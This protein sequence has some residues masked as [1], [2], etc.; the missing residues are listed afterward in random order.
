M[1]H[2]F[3]SPE[4]VTEMAESPGT[5]ASRAYDVVLVSILALA[6]HAPEGPVTAVA[7]AVDAHYERA[8]S[9]AVYAYYLR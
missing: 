7:R 2:P 5:A 9:D 4:D 1:H 3:T 6:P 8:G